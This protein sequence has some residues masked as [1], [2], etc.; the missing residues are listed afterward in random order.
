VERELEAG[1]VCMLRTTLSID[2]DGNVHKLAEIQEDVD[3]HE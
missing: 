3:L 1:S 2:S